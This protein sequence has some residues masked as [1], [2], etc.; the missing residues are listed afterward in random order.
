M[1]VSPL[2]LFTYCLEC[3]D[4]VGSASGRASGLQKIEWWGVGVFICLERCADCL[5][6]VQLMLLHHKT[7][8]SLASF[9]SRLALPFWCQ[10]TQVVLERDNLGN[11]GS[12]RLCL[13]SVLWQCYSEE[14]L[15]HKKLNDELRCFCG[16]CLE[17]GAKVLYMIVPVPLPSQSPVCLIN[18]LNHFAISIPAYLEEKRPLNRCLFTWTFLP[19]LTLYVN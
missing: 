5:H 16:I 9:K 3:F 13:P 1:I 10:I 14:H 19:I 15:V 11:L 4:T 8:P 2:Y 18:F 7:P 12:H 6:M 17:W